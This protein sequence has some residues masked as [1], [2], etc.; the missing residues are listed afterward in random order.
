M[1]FQKPAVPTSQDVESFKSDAYKEIAGISPSLAEALKAKYAEHPQSLDSPAEVLEVLEKCRSTE[2]ALIVCSG[3]YV[4]AAVSVM[5]TMPHW[6]KAGRPTK[7][8]TVEFNFLQKFGIGSAEYYKSTQQFGLLS[9]AMNEIEKN[10]PEGTTLNF[11]AAIKLG[12]AVLW[13]QLVAMCQKLPKT[14][15]FLRNRLPMVTN[16]YD[17]EI[18]KDDP[19]LHTRFCQT[20]L[21]V[22]EHKATILKDPSKEVNFHLIKAFERS[23]E[24]HMKIIEHRERKDALPSFYE[25]DGKE[26]WETMLAKLE[27]GF[28]TVQ[29]LYSAAKASGDEL[30]EASGRSFARN[31]PRVLS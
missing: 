22:Q 11:E 14:A 24:L 3:L 2:G 23:T 12:D 21:E 16:T 6:N 9:R 17:S 10:I 20:A 31:A 18:N 29:E 26:V 25:G 8:Q 15:E 27:D 30:L 5:D 19:K 1:S 28:K 13:K 4:D 7:A